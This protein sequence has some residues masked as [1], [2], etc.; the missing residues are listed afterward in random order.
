MEVKKHLV[1]EEAF[2]I[3]SSLLLYGTWRWENCEQTAGPEAVS[4]LGAAPLTSCTRHREEMRSHL[5][6]LAE[7]LTTGECGLQGS[8]LAPWHPCDAHEC[9]QC[10]QAQEWS[11]G[12]WAV[13]ACI[14]GWT[15]LF[16]SWVRPSCLFPQTKSFLMCSV[17]MIPSEKLL[18]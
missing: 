11:G 9:L 5:L 18:F 7:A 12:A 14:Q 6:P 15:S 13:V 2:S 16:L 3:N 17:F 4:A 1:R 10:L 8:I